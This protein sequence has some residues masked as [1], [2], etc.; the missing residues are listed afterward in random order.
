MNEM[1]RK[2]LQ[3]T[4]IIALLKLSDFS[5][6]THNPKLFWDKKKSKNS[7]RSADLPL[8]HPFNSFF[9]HFPFI[10]TDDKTVK[11]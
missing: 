5:P 9:F 1:F 8:N 4:K 2:K 3:K 6:T 10:F 11:Y 7:Y